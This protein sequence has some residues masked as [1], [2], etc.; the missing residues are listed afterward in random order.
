MLRIPFSWKVTGSGR[1]SP[2]SP[3]PAARNPVEYLFLFDKLKGGMQ[4]LHT[5]LSAYL[6][7][8]HI[9]ADIQDDLAFFIRCGKP[10]ADIPLKEPPGPFLIRNNFHSR[11]LQL[12]GAEMLLAVNLSLLTVK[13]AGAQVGGGEIHITI[14]LRYRRVIRQEHTDPILK[15]FAVLPS[16][17]TDIGIAV[18]IQGFQRLTARCFFQNIEPAVLEPFTP[19]LT[20]SAVYRSPSPYFLPMNRTAGMLCRYVLIDFHGRFPSFFEYRTSVLNHTRL[21]YFCQGK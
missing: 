9:M 21:L 2:L 17:Q 7:L 10:G 15:G 20:E 13:P 12:L 3:T 18:F 1:L 8:F 6:I 4:S 14:P 5:A 11:L 19:L 16:H